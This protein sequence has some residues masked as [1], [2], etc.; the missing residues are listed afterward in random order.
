MC[1]KFYKSSY[2]LKGVSKQ[3]AMLPSAQRIQ[4][5]SKFCNLFFLNKMA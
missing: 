1:K 2:L 4:S 5:L 3:L